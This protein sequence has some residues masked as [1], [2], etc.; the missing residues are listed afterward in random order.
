MKHGAATCGYAPCWHGRRRWRLSVASAPIPAFAAPSERTVPGTGFT[1]G[2]V[3][4]YGALVDEGRRL[5]YNRAPPTAAGC[6]DLLPRSASM[7]QAL[8]PARTMCD[9]FTADSPL[10]QSI[11]RISSPRSARAPLISSCRNVSLSASVPA[12]SDAFSGSSSLIDAGV[13]CFPERFAMVSSV[14]VLI[15]S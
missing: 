9:R 15:Q 12:G 2:T 5:R 11:R 10:P 4:T 13:F 6:S 1:G 8:S 7:V 14:T 3:R